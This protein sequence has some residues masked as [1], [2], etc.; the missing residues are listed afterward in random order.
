MRKICF[1]AFA[2]AVVTVFAGDVLYWQGTSDWLAWDD[3]AHWSLVKG[4]YSN[5]DSRVPGSE[6]QLYAYGYAYSGD[7]GQLGYFDLG[8]TAHAVAGFSAGSAVGTRYKSYQMHL[9]NGSLTIANPVNLDGVINGFDV[10]DG[11]TLKLASAQ[12]PKYMLRSPGVYSYWNIQEGGRIEVRGQEIQFADV[13]A[14]ISSGGT[15]LFDPD[16]FSLHNSHSARLTQFN[17]HGQLIAPRGLVW[18]GTDIFTSGVKND[19]VPRSTTRQKRF[20]ITQFEGSEVLLGGN[21]VKTTEESANLTDGFA[22]DYRYVLAGGTLVASNSVKFYNATSRWGAETSAEMTGSATAHVLTGAT[23]DMGDFTYADGV[24]LTKTGA[25]LLKVR[26]QPPTLQVVDGP[27]QFCQPLTDLSGVTLNAGTKLVFGS[28][29]NVLEP[30]AN[31]TAITYEFANDIVFS[32]TRVLTSSDADF[33]AYVQA[34]LVAAGLPAGS[35]LRIEGNTILL[36][37]DPDTVLYWK[38]SPRVWA[39][40]DAP[41]NWSV[42]QTSAFNP[43]NLVPGTAGAQNCLWAYG[44]ET[45]NAGDYSNYYGMFDLGGG[46]YT[47]PGFAAGATTGRQNWHCQQFHVTNGYLRIEHATPPVVNEGIG[48][49]VWNEATLDLCGLGTKISSANQAD[50]WGVSGLYDQLTVKRGGRANILN[51]VVFLNHKSIVQAG[52][53][54][55]FRDGRFV[56]GHNAIASRPTTVEN[57]GTL[58]LPQGLCWV[59]DD[60]TSGGDL[61]KQFRVSQLAG[62]MLIGGDFTKIGEE[63]NSRRGKMSFVFSGGVLSATN[64][65][66]FCNGTTRNGQETFAEVAANAAV[67]VRVLGAESMLDMSLFTYG[68]NASVT[69]NGLGRLVMAARPANLAVNAGAVAFATA[70]T[71]WTGVTLADGV[72][73]VW[74]ARGNACAAPANWQNLSFGL[75]T[76]AFAL[77]DT[78]L[79]TSDA[80]FRAYVAAQIAADAPA[81]TRVV[82]EDDA[83]KLALDS[84]DFFTADG[85]LDLSDPNGWQGGSVPVGH[86]IVVQGA[87]TVARLSAATPAFKSIQ[88]V[89]GATLLVTDDVDVPRLQLG[90]VATVRVAP[91]VTVAITNG[92]AAAGDAERLPILEVPTNA[93]LKVAANTVFKNLDLRLYG[94]ITTEDNSTITFGGAANGETAYFAMTSIGGTIRLNAWKGTDLSGSL[95]RYVVPEVGGTVIVTRPILLRDTTFALF[96]PDTTLQGYCGTLVGYGNP[97]AQPFAFIL[98]NSSWTLYRANVFGGAA[99]V[100]ITNGAT[101]KVGSTHPG[102]ATYMDV[103]DAASL[104]VDGSASRLL[105]E[106]ADP[107]RNSFQPTQYGTP[108]LRVRNGGRVAAHNTKGNGNAFLHFED[109]VYEVPNLPYLPVDYNP[110]PTDKDPRNWMSDLFQGFNSVVVPAGKTLRLASADV[111]GANNGAPESIRYWNRDVKL[112]NVPITGAGDVVMANGTPG[113]SFTATVVSGANTATGTISVENAPDRTTLLFNDGANWAGTVVAGNIGFTNTTA[114]AAPAKAT[115]ANLRLSGT[116]PIRVWESAQGVTNDMFDVTGEL[117]LDGGALQPVGVGGA[118]RA[119]KLTLTVGRIPA[120]AVLPPAARCWKASAAE[121]VGGQKLLTL[122]YRRPG[123]VVNFR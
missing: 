105:L 121:V 93:T 97:T 26:A 101:L 89:D 112:A 17:V 69:K 87:A 50:W 100:C 65:V 23:L 64:A 31:Y 79:T 13:N 46:S 98:D 120:A 44:C 39:R 117:T 59:G 61:A 49:H 20:T 4:D 54:L 92:L 111:L 40:W 68:A 110:C 108:S 74:G 37:T 14:T 52:G 3:A 56:I 96:R 7:L 70:L 75:D 95:H 91:G 102:V 122:T 104:V 63:E 36:E 88:V 30:L 34:A 116:L 5:P 45:W 83:I 84:G 18:N 76:A 81:K 114:A 47:I 119:D 53:T 80:D 73:V 35:T 19:T 22:C 113:Y 10:Y 55:A 48:Y 72:K 57:S 25:G 85:E 42:S 67:E 62:E 15:L 90:A 115:F 43:L 103:R 107:Y 33:L 24:T 123:I 41:E 21:F 66:A 77:G 1:A 2:I 38:G 82:V 12:T 16:K 71:D 78:V 51:G 118:I 60:P 27:V 99:E 86:E 11:T 29:D 32:S 58:L 9:R 28:S 109:G 6:D 106:N 8:G 94:T